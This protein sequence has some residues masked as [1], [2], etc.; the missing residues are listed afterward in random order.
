MKFHDFRK[1]RQEI[2]H[3]VI[4]WIIMIFMLHF[5]PP[6]LGIQFTRAFFETV[7][8]IPA[9][10][11]I[12]RHVPQGRHVL[13]RQDERIIFSPMLDGNR[14]AKYWRKYIQNWDAGMRRGIEL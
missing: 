3:A 13:L 6:Q 5:F 14:L 2:S 1:M 9:A 11:E 8:V 4:S 12:N 7:V 10:I